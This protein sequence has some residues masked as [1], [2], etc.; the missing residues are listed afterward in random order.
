LFSP[1]W[2]VYSP[3]SFFDMLTESF[4]GFHDMAGG[5][6]VGF[7]DEEGNTTRGRSSLVEK[8]SDVWAVTAVP[9]VSPFALSDL[10]SPELLQILF[11]VGR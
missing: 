8:A 5:Q 7:Y 1:T 4:A 6:L 2:G 11:A 10:V 9:L 3:G